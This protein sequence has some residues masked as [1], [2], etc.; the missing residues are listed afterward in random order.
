MFASFHWYGWILLLFKAYH[1]RLSNSMQGSVAHYQLI[2]SSPMKFHAS[3]S[4]VPEAIWIDSFTFLFQ[5]NKGMPYPAIDP[6]STQETYPHYRPGDSFRTKA[7]WF[8]W[9]N[10]TFPP[11]PKQK[12][13]V[14]LFQP[15]ATPF[16]ICSSP[17]LNSSWNSAASLPYVTG[18]CSKVSKPQNTVLRNPHPD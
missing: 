12:H 5:E 7:T 8:L 13:E 1:R 9:T 3:P 11:P 16:P 17:F 18:S 4:E 6:H 10:S 15:C 14:T 2:S